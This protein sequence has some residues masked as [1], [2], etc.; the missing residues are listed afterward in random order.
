MHHLMLEVNSLDDVGTALDR[1][2]EK[3]LPLAMALGHH[4]NDRMT[5]FYVRSPS[6]FEIEYGWGGLLVNDDDWV[7]RSYDSGSVWGHK[8]P[9]DAPMPGMLRPFQPAAT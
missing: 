8:R 3:K 5:S 6:G 1:C 7:V 2:I 9:D 4:T